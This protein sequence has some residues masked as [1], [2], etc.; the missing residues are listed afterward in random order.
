METILT[1]AL[2]SLIFTST[3]Q[4]AYYYQA[5]KPN[6][7]LLVGLHTWNGD[8]RQKMSIKYL[9]MAVRN[10]WNFVHPE[11][12]TGGK[13]KAMRDID[14]AIEFAKA[15]NQ[16]SQI[17]IAGMSGGGHAALQYLAHYPE[18]PAIVMSFGAPTNLHRWR[19]ELKPET[20]YVHDIERLTKLRPA[21][22]FVLS[23]AER[24][25]NTNTRAKIYITHGLNDGTIDYNHAIAV[26]KTLRRKGNAAYLRIVDAG[27]YD[28][29]F[30]TDVEK[31]ILGR[32]PNPR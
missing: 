28:D 12:E 9:D 17:I 18:S 19:K 27:H 24:L 26:F 20:I 8:Y 5:S 22:N 7:P 21:K 3:G 13:R 31:I 15:D 4:P 1:W 2:A 6:R 11:Y 32:E 30:F 25:F 23:P 10:D 29:S 16:P 14:A